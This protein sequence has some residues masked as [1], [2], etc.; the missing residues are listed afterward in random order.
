MSDISS[1]K[2]KFM[3]WLW[4]FLGRRVKPKSEI[5]DLKVAVLIP[6]YNEVNHIAR[7]IRSIKSQ[8]RAP[9]RIIV[10]DD[11]STDGTGDIA[12]ASAVEAVRTS[13]NTGTKSQAL[14]YGLE[15]IEPAEYPV[16]FML[17]ADT[18]LAPDAI[19]QVLPYLGNPEVVSVCSFVVPQRIRTIWERGRFIEYLIGITLYKEAQNRWGSPLVS[20]GCFSAYKT[21]SVKDFGGFREGTIAEDMDLTWRFLC[22]GKKVDLA[23]EAICYPLEPN[24][25]SCFL[26]QTRRWRRGFLQNI[27]VHKLGLWQKKSL[28]FFAYWYLLEGLIAPL[29]YGAL[30]FFIYHWEK[31]PTLGEVWLLYM[32]SELGLI[33]S[34]ALFKGLQLKK[35]KLVLGSLPFYFLLDLI[36]TYVFWESIWLEWIKKK[37]IGV[38]QK[39]HP[40]EVI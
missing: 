37:R 38:W 40:Q 10:V 1:F 13:Q 18:I 3:Y 24:N 32:L 2:S 29:K 28:F 11:C 39:G 14:N 33:A 25:F 35:V 30:A 27:A 17:D 8:T 12:K 23:S 6:A 9:D 22:S 4:W 31:I 19:K 15:F 20:S 5:D 36:Y 26:K 7:T 34:V 21:Q 16:V